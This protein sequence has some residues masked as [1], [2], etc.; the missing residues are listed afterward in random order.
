MKL[1]KHFAYKYKE[2]EHYKNVIVLPEEIVNKLG[3]GVGV[4]LQESTDGD[5][6]VLKPLG[7]SKQRPKQDR[8]EL[9]TRTRRMR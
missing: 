2:K 9:N 3:W 8:S 7:A 4:E 1:Q 6:L 5:A